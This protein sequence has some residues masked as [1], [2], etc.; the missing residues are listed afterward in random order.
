MAALTTERLQEI[1][2]DAGLEA[3]EYSG[4]FMYGKVCVSFNTENMP[5]DI[6]EIVNSVMDD[7]ERSE[8]VKALRGAR[9]D[10]M[11]K[12]ATVVYFPSF[13]YAEG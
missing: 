4:R 12:S 6:A 10:Q 1:I 5:R 11:G 8:V 3:Q 7:D 2:E 9:T 13:R